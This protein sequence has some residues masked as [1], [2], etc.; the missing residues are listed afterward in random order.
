M[1]N[2]TR[3]KERFD[4]LVHMVAA[5]VLGFLSPDAFYEVLG[6][7]FEDAKKKMED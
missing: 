2:N 4:I 6:E 1:K 5:G 7:V 3:L